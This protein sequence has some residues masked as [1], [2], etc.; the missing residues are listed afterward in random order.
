ML[1]G[2]LASLLSDGDG[3]R[4]GLDWK[5]ATSLK[6]CIKHFN[7]WRK[8]CVRTVTNAAKR[9]SFI[10]LPFVACQTQPHRTAGWLSSSLASSTSCSDRTLFREWHSEK[11]FRASDVLVQAHRRVEAGTLT[12][13]DYEDMEKSMGLNWNPAGILASTTLRSRGSRIRDPP[14]CCP[15]GIAARGT[16]TCKSRRDGLS[17]S[18]PTSTCDV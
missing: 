5:G 1:Y 16:S 17:T 11:V 8:D 7:V 10:L 6:P 12:N 2:K 14:R 3:L 4:M 15:Q 18:G 13:T 9:A